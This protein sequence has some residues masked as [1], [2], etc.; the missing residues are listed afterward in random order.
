MPEICRSAL[1]ALI[2]WIVAIA[3]LA[4]A[5]EQATIPSVELT[6]SH[7]ALCKV[8]VGDSLSLADLPQLDG[9]Q[10]NFA[11]LMGDKA[12]VVAIWH[13]DGP[14][15]RMA[16]GDLQ[17]D[18]V[19]KLGDQ[20]IAVVGIAVGESPE[21]T[22]KILQQA[23]ASFTNLLDAKRAT[24]DVVGN[25]RLPRIYVLDSQ[26]TIQW[27]DIEYSNATRRELNQ[28]LQAIAAAH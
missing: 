11:D 27:F 18:V 23:E 17:R 6:A 21:S 19:A 7:A 13:G 8:K 25:D 15:T 24:L 26:G 1:L 9:A 16:L 14:M 20:G 4:S 3:P 10:A 5:Q 28:T 22:K 2:A 12:T